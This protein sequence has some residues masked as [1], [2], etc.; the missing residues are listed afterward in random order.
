MSKKLVYSLGRRGFFSEIN[1]LVLAIIYSKR[2]GYNLIVNTF[3]WNYRIKK[4]LG[5]YFKCNLSVS[6]NPL[7]AQMT[8]TGISEKFNPMSLH[9]WFYKLCEYQNKIYDAISRN[10]VWGKQVYNQ[11]RS[12]SF[13]N[14][15]LRDEFS[16]ELGEILAL[17]ETIGEK[18]KSIRRDI[19]LPDDFIGV[20]IRRGDKITT[21]EMDNISL[22]RYVSKI[23]EYDID[24]VYIATDDIS[25][26]NSIREALDNKYKIYHNP[27]LK[28]NGFN[29]GAFNKL[30]KRAKQMEAETLLTDM[31]ILFDSKNFI[32]TYS[33]NLSRVVP[34]I[35]GFDKCIS[36]DDEWSIG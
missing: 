17:N 4:G 15:I 24:D 14:S 26:I 20:H 16:K 32:G 6:N 25:T 35:I 19:G 8:R 11:L 36:L 28:T 31:F 22:K 5:D 1:N 9:D 34:C 10:M 18:V 13:R 27:C 23:E 29:E 2:Y 30:S 12:P 33:S 21:G 7:S 3:Y